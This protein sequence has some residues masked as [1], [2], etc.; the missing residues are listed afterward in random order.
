M[1]RE[2]V[3]HLNKIK[4]VLSSKMEIEKLQECCICM[5]Q[6]A[7]GQQMV[8]LECHP[9]H[10]FHYE[11]LRQWLVQGHRECPLCRVQIRT[12]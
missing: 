4:A 6:F 1:T 9:L 12:A 2:R 3:A 7:L 5:D 10:I 11:C 8:K